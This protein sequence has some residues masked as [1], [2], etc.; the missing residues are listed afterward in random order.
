MSQWIAIPVLIILAL[1]Q[2]TLLSWIS[3]AGIKID[4]ALTLVVAWGLVGPAGEAAIW[5]F[6][7]GI[8]L[9]LVSGLP[10]GTQTL[11]LAAIGWTL[12]LPV[13]DEFRGN[14]FLPPAAILLA[15]FIYNLIAL[16][17]LSL[18]GW[19][20]S[21]D[22]YL[23]RLTLPS[24]IVNTLTLPFLYFPLQWISRRRMY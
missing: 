7:A 21:W 11:A 4:L 19:Q 6:V 10:F 16:T 8:V 18:V 23:L 13:L 17:V 20:V 5:G 14:L 3:I 12:S 22:E 1:A 15:T 2:A 24:A 9:D